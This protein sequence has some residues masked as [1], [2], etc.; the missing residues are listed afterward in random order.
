MRLFLVLDVCV[1]VS[2][3]VPKRARLCGSEPGQQDLRQQEGPS[4]AGGQPGP[5]G[6]T[7]RDKTRSPSCVARLSLDWIT[8]AELGK[9]HVIDQRRV[10][11]IQSYGLSFPMTGSRPVPFSSS[12]G[13]LWMNITYLFLHSADTECLGAAGSEVRMTGIVLPSWSSQSVRKSKR[14]DSL[15]QCEHHCYKSLG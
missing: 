5:P 14:T 4:Q 11:K 8:C 9:G 10:C 13:N 7:A 15:K 12:S 6:G 2:V 1:H 3:C